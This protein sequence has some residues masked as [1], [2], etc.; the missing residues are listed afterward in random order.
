MLS[1]S[2][3]CK[4]H[5]TSSS[6]IDNMVSFNILSQNYMKKFLNQSYKDTI[7]KHNNN[8]RKNKKVFSTLA[9]NVIFEAFKGLH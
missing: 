4:K 6:H 7:E 2:A 1:M 8:V 9:N 3:R 5:E